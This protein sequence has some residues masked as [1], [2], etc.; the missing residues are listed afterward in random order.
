MKSSTHMFVMSIGML[1]LS[2][3]VADDQLMVSLTAFSAGW[4]AAFGIATRD[5]E[6]TSDA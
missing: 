4:C 2:F 5:M 1:G 6:K 3:F